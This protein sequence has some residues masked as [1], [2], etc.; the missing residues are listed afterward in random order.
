[1]G[2]P[3]GPKPR[4]VNLEV[5]NVGRRAAR[6]TNLYWK[7]GIFRRKTYIWMAPDGDRVG[8]TL[9]D[10]D[11]ANFRVR[12]EPFDENFDDVARSDADSWVK[13]FFVRACVMTSTGRRFEARVEP[14]LRRHLVERARSTAA[15]VAGEGT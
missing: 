12:I 11:E 8:K 7:T 6:I 13:S 15:S 4:F 2:D 9:S 14:A 1:M 10:G 5:T 3:P